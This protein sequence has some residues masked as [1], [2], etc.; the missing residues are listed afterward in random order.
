MRDAAT[1][2]VDSTRDVDS[3]IYQG[4]TTV[5]AQQNIVGV[6]ASDWTVSKDH[7][8]YTF[9]I[10]AGVKWADGQPLGADDVLF[11]WR[12]LRDKGRPNHRYYYGKVARA[13]KVGERAVR[14][15]ILEKA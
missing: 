2:T 6:L 5:D 9:N 11:S 14:F 4:L 8:T 13:E 15:E 1:F 12:L 7:L 3:V 10:R